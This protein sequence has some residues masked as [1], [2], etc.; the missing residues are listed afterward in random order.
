MSVF[1]LA[2]ERECQPYCN[3]Y[4]SAFSYILHWQILLVALYL[5][6][7]DANM[8]PQNAEVSI[9]SILM[10]CN[11]LLMVKPNAQTASP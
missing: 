11:I 7:L 3:I 5:L 2:I 6:L 9:G 4:I 10:S 1:F 8:T